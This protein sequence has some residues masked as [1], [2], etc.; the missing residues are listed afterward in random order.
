[1]LNSDQCQGTMQRLFDKQLRRSR[2]K[3]GEVNIEALATAV[4][5]TYEDFERDRHRIDRANRLMAQEV[6]EAHKNL[7]SAAEALKVQNRRFEV[8][9]NNMGQGLCMVDA[10]GN[11]VVHNQRLI[12]ILGLPTNT[13]TTGLSVADFMRPCLN[14][15]ANQGIVLK[16]TEMYNALRASPERAAVH[17]QGPKGK[18][19]L[20]TH[21][22]MSD[23]GFVHTFE[24][25]T[26]RKAAEAKAL[27][28]ALHDVLTD[29]PNRRLLNERM[30]DQSLKSGAGSSYA[31]LCLDLDRFKA[32]NDSLGHAAGDEL[33]LTVTRRLQGCVRACDTVARL[34]GDEFAVL[35][36]G[37]AEEQFAGNLARRLVKALGKPYQILGSVV[38]ISVSIGIALS[39]RDASAPD[40]LIRNAD[41]ALYQAKKDG[42]SCF[43]FFETEMDEA[44]KLRRS[45]EL[46]LREA[47]RQNQFELN[48]QP[49][50]EMK[51]R[52]ICGFE[53]LL[54]WNCPSRGLIS[55]DQFIPMA[56]ELGLIS[57]IGEWVLFEACHEAIA[58][59]ANVRVAVNV[60]VKQFSGGTLLPAVKNALRC[61]GLNPDR[62]E[63]EITESVLLDSSGEVLD[64]LHQLRDMGV[65]IVMDDFGTGYSS[66]AYLRSFPF[67]KVKIDRSFISGLGSET[68][69]IA[70]VRAVTGLCNGLGIAT[71]AEG[72]ETSQQLEILNNEQCT[73]VQGYLFS[74][75]RKRADIQALFDQQKIRN[76]AIS[77][78]QLVSTL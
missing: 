35:L 51:T 72:V 3:L 21:E 70:I 71:T 63:L 65:S 1:M 52:Q 31:V 74:K 9:L 68:D 66:L 36:S 25:V 59:P 16:I 30:E 42:K 76:Q 54:R 20:V 44:A 5:A 78:S 39:N 27:H 2:N 24:D 4:V 64:L 38:N 50:I 62:L 75:P 29:L 77:N 48:Y 67:D 10:S 40:Q 34:G 73:Q 28:L 58:W 43:R 13:E 60:S 37:V 45:M 7:T 47:L 61:S 46:D 26:A 12:Q 49:L 17:I 55:P 32:V 69:S 6:E 19:I 15:L 11:V 22:P 23:G 33:L 56:E 14:N 8:A 57:E 41:L 53:A 18:T